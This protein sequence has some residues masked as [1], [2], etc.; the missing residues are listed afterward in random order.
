MDQPRHFTATGYVVSGDALLL[1]WHAKVQAWLPPGGHVEPNEDPVQAVLRE[2]IE[3]TGIA[4]E[5][6]AASPVL[7]IA[8]QAQLVPPAAI[9]VEEIHDPVGG[10]HE[11]IDLIY[12]CRPTGAIAPLMDGCRWVARRDLAEG[13]PLEA[14]RR[15]GT[16]SRGRPAAG[17]AG[18]PD[19][20]R[21]GIA[22]G[23]RLLDNP[24][25]AL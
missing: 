13:V 20:W 17:R 21:R 4:A 9:L 5:V 1:H 11:H 7:D 3:E 6:V 18:V 15:A 24:P 23:R 16:S 25:R 12:F 8:W 14:R 10:D 2:V 19:C 22:L